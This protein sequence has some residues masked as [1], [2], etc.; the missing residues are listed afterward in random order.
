MR[1]NER[2]N[3]TLRKSAI[4]KVKTMRIMIILL[5]VLWMIFFLLL[6]LIH[7]DLPRNVDILILGCV[8]A[9][10]FLLGVID[11]IFTRIKCRCPFCG[12][13][14][15]MVKYKRFRKHS[16]DFINNTSEYSCYNCKENI[17][18]I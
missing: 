14:W 3:L 13:A 2:K 6:R 10:C 17:E 7:V 16:L 4:R 9:V 12:R 15:S 1:G 11:H 8:I 18:I 5:P